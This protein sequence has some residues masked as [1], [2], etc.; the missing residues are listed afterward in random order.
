MENPKLK[1]LIAED[2]KIPQRLLSI[3]LGKLSG[4]EPDIVGNGNEI[5]AV[6]CQNNYDL[7]F[8]DYHMPG[9]NGAEVVRQICEDRS[10]N[11]QP[12]I[13]GLSGSLHGDKKEFENAGIDQF[14]NKPITLQQLKS[15]LSM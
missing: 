3:L 9:S 7:I 1:I 10:L 4:T 15:V 11:K 8:M 5:G 2:D 14:I 12:F 6:V 13:V